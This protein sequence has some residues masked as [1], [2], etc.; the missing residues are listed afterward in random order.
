MDH[1]GSTD[2][3]GEK[4]KDSTKFFSYRTK[5]L[6]KWAERE[7]RR[8]CATVPSDG[9]TQKGKQGDKVICRSGK[10]LSF[11]SKMM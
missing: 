7:L 5:N 3:G 11:L 4:K 9:L 2:L 10:L 8:L 6:L 1:I